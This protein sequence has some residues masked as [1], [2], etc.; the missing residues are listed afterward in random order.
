MKLSLVLC[1]ALVGSA[2]AQD[3]TAPALDVVDRA[4]LTKAQEHAKAA[5]AACAALPEVIRYNAYREATNTQ[6]EAKHQ[7]YALDWATL[8]LKPKGGK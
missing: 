2:L 4:L 3:A 6:I 5:Q 7:G 8:V 1:L